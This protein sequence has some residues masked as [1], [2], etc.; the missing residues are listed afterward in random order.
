M[1]M[2]S[3]Q[4]DSTPSCS[5]KRLILTLLAVALILLIPSG[6]TLADS[7]VPTVTNTPEATATPT[8]KPPTMTP[9]APDIAAT[10]TPV[11]IIPTEVTDDAGAIDIATPLPDN[12]GG[13]ST[14]D[15]I[16]LML[17]AVAVVIIIGVIVYVF[18]HQTRGGLGER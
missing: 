4:P 15:R 18:I 10:N 14:I 6:G 13:L 9:E 12:A 16:L 8:S 5:C 11:P 2:K 7:N 3:L 1:K 17:L